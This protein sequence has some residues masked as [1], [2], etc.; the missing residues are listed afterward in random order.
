MMTSE[1]PLLTAARRALSRLDL[2]AR[3]ADAFSSAPSPSGILAVGKCAGAMLDGARRALPP[4]WSGP[5]CAILPD[6]APPPTGSDVEILRGAHPYPDVRT[7][8]AAAR[9]LALSRASTSERPLWFCLSGGGSACLGAPLPGVSVAELGEVSRALM[10]RGADIR[11]LNTVRK[12]LCQALGGRLGAVAGGLRVAVAVD[13]LDEDLALVASGPALPDETTGADA[14]AVLDRH[15]LTP[16]LPAAITRALHD[17]TRVPCPTWPHVPVA[18][19]SQ[20]RA[21]LAEEVRPLGPVQV[22]TPPL[23]DPMDVQARLVPAMP[24]GAPLLVDVSEVSFPVPAEA[25]PGGRS[26]HL[27]LWLAR[28][29][30]GSAFAFLALGSDGRDGPTD[31]AGALVTHHTLEGIPGPDVDRAL[32]EGAARELL[33]ARGALV[34]RFP[35]ELNLLD[36]HLLW[37]SP[38][39]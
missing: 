11:E 26:M 18:T 24:G 13:I 17:H 22:L 12:H 21:L 27:A 3:T 20:L 14:R 23:R 10:L 39:G 29:V 6:G 34:P 16:T 32:A 38:P 28:A 9:A 33:R 25:P 36:V 8:V 19:P 1:H 37:R 15:G 5:V 2:R 4:S 35:S 7:T 31:H 30:R